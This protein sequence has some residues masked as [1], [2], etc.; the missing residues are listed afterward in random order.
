MTVA[1]IA[2]KYNVGE[3][4][5]KAHLTKEGILQTKDQKRVDKKWCA[6]LRRTGSSLTPGWCRVDV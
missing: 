2:A 3:P 1:E 4:A 5:V 6:A